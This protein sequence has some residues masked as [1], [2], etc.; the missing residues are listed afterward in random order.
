MKKIISAA[1]AGIL[2]TG[3]LTACGDSG[4]S[5]KKS[6]GKLSDGRYASIYGVDGQF[7]SIAS[8]D[9][10][11]A[12]EYGIDNAEDFYYIEI[13]GK[14]FETSMLN[15]D[16]TFIYTGDYSVQ[17]GKID[18]EYKEFRSYKDGE[19]YDGPI[20]VAD[21]VPEYDMD[22]VNGTSPKLDGLS[23]EEKKQMRA[24]E[25]AKV[26][27]KARVEQMEKWNKTGSY[28]NLILPFS[29]FNDK[30]V[31][32]NWIPEVRWHAGSRLGEDETMTLKAVDDLICTDTYG[33]KLDGKYKQGDDFTLEY[34]IMDTI[35]DDEIS[36]YNVFTD[37]S[38][39]YTMDQIISSLEIQ[40]GASDFNTTL[41]FS[42]GEWSWYN[43]YDE[44]INNGKYAESSDYPGLI[45]MYI[46]EDSKYDNEIA[47]M[48][49]QLLYFGKDGKVYYPAFAKVD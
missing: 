40:Y 5:E 43:C 16:K 26:A 44:L 15:S 9:L 14:S 35:K 31:A 19:Q 25:Q 28:C 20:S 11:D 7:R 12:I 17:S 21:G 48:C 4:K 39:E 22:I 1:L 24:E 46:D 29:N 23:S 41:E 27:Q 18:F 32:Y 36:P 34:N 45:M 42:D 33:I 3:A 47:E 30:F 8:D 49:P 6:G 10:D 38:Y 13:D 2:C 37:G